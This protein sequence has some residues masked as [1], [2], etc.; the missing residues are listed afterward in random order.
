MYFLSRRRQHLR[1]HERVTILSLA[2]Q[3]FMYALVILVL[4]SLL[5]LALTI[6]YSSRL[7]TTLGEENSLIIL[8]MN[9][10]GDHTGV[11]LCP[12]ALGAGEAV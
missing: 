5:K 11:G 8:H 6:H 7:C 10:V 3:I 1:Q 9:P 2:K 12:A 4:S